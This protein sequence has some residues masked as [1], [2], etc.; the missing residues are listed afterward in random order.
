[1]LSF[2]NVRIVFTQQTKFHNISA[3]PVYHSIHD[4]FQYVKRFVDP[5]FTTHLAIAQV[6]GSVAYLLS[7]TLLLPINCSDY[8]VALNIALTKLQDKYGDMLK[9]EKISLGAYCSHLRV[10][11]DSV[12]EN[13]SERNSR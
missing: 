4:T 10:Y 11:S 6:W 7:D 5:H 9:K 2:Y 12:K 13:E 1:M 8:A 3:Y